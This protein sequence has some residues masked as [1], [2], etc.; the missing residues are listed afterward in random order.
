MSAVHT[1]S[2]SAAI[3]VSNASGSIGGGSRI[4]VTIIMTATTATTAN[5]VITND[6]SGPR[7]HRRRRR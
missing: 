1:T 7:P 2:T 6:V 4:I 5:R 3:G